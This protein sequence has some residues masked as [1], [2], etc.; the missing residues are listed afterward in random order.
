MGYGGASGP[1]NRSADVID[2]GGGASADPTQIVVFPPP[3]ATDVPPSFDTASEG[4]TPPPPPGGGTVTGP[5]ISVLFDTGNSSANISVHELRD[6]AGNLLPHT[7]ISP[8]T[9]QI[10]PF[11][12]NSFAFYADGPAASGATFSVHIEGTSNGTAFTKDWSFTTSTPPTMAF[13][14]Y[15]SSKGM[16]GSK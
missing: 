9:P 7:F 12:T 8:S 13:R 5:I 6:S 16:E 11:M 15:F 4:P 1:N 10:G 2:F 14:K 3:D